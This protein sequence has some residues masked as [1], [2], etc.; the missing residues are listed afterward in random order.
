MELVVSSRVRR[1]VEKKDDF[2]SSCI[3]AILNELLVKFEQNKLVFK[4]TI[5]V[6][7]RK[8]YYCSSIWFKVQSIVDNFSYRKGCSPKKEVGGR[9]IGW[10]I[11][12]H[13]YI[14]E[15]VSNDLFALKMSI[16]SSKFVITLFQSSIT[17]NAFYE[18]QI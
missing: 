15:K 18:P 16:H 13:F 6:L 8:F 2:S 7:R 4:N 9:K 3:F 5:N 11:T 10:T 12:A 14:L 17:K 1:C